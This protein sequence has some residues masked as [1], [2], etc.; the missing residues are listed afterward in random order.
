MQKLHFEVRRVYM[1]KRDFIPPWWLRNRHVQT[2]WP[3]LMRPDVTHLNLTRERL[4]LP[5]GDFIDLEWMNANQTGP[6]II[7]L[8]GFE[9][10]LSS[11]YVKSLL[12]KLDKAHFRAVFMYFRGC[13]G[14]PNRL[15]RT[16]HS[17]ETSDLNYLVNVLRYREPKTP[18]GA[19]GY[20][21]GGNV[22]LKWLGETGIENPIRT[23]IAISPPLDLQ[24]SSVSINSG[25]LRFYERYLV[26]SAVTRLQN[27]L[28][29]LAPLVD[30]SKLHSAM[31]IR[32]FDHHVTV[33]LHGFANV[34][35]YYLKSSSRYYLK[36]IKVPTLLICAADDP[37]LTPDSFPS[38]DEISTAVCLELTRYGGH[39]G[40]VTGKYPWRVEYWLDTR[41]PE[42]L[43][44]HF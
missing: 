7:I 22:L 37:F 11:H 36:N 40:F 18:L 30:L 8:H 16:Y 14:E 1:Q 19:I 34:D 12:D 17:G 6:I 38:A 35:D 5:D 41:I 43:S 33:P 31:S 15:P 3:Y 23:A 27:R 42:F 29:T 2:V 9:G 21:L 28:K 20:S 39:V 24:K 26:R 4:E 32:D 13:S 44:H 10:N 25:I